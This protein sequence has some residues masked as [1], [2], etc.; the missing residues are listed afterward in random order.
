MSFLDLRNP[1][2]CELSKVTDNVVSYACKGNATHE[3]EKQASFDI[4][5][6]SEI[7]YSLFY[8]NGVKRILAVI[9]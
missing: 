4:V 2:L 6:R 7:S 1:D 3:A 8:T 5:T 9:I